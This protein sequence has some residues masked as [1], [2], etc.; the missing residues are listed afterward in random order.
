M[1]R[2]AII[3]LLLI[4][5]LI[6]LIIWLVLHKAIDKP[7]N[8]SID[9]NDIQ[10][11][12]FYDF[13][14]FVMDNTLKFIYAFLSEYPGEWIFLNVSVDCKKEEYGDCYESF[15]KFKVNVG[16]WY[17]SI[18]SA[19]KDEKEYITEVYDFDASDNAFTYNMPVAARYTNCVALCDAVR[20]KLFNYLDVYD[21]NNP[22]RK[23]KRTEYG[24]YHTWN[25]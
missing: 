25:L 21:N 24:I 20:K 23:L 2:V 13:F 16:S 8:N 19:H 14:A 17:G 3:I 11:G 22:S 9:E 5:V 12:D 15:L 7:A 6:G 18:L 4:Q 10:I 1:R